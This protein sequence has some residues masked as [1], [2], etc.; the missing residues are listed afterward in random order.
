[1]DAGLYNERIYIQIKIDNLVNEIY[2]Q[3]DFNVD[4]PKLPAEYQNQKDSM[5]HIFHFLSIFAST[6]A[7]ERISQILNLD[8]LKDVKINMEALRNTSLKNILEG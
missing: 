3:I 7:R 5:A 8:C 4:K 1:M 2:S 6:S